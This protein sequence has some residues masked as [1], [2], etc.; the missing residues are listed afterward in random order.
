MESDGTL[1][2]PWLDFCQQGFRAGHA[3]T[4]VQ[5]LPRVLRDGPDISPA[6][7]FMGLQNHQKYLKKYGAAKIVPPNREIHSVAVVDLKSHRPGYDFFLP[8][9]II[10]S[11]EG[12]KQIPC[13]A[14]A[15]RDSP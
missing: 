9:C 1:C 3:G 10:F 8:Q 11:T 2:F 7:F 4:L 12:L 14:V 6:F 5:M 13:H 15:Q